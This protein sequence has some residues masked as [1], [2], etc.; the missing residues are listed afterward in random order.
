MKRS[1]QDKLIVEI[2][3]VT[4][5]LRGRTA[6]LITDVTQVIGSKWLVSDFDGAPPRFMTLE[7]PVRYAEMLLARRLQEMG[8]AEQG[9]RTLTHWKQRRGETGSELFFTTV[10]GRA[11]RV[12]E[13]RSF[14][15]DHPHLLFSSN[16]L[17][18]AVAADHWADHTV[19]VMFEHD[20]HLDYVVG[21]AGK[22]LTAGRLSTYAV[23]ARE[24]LVESI[25]LELR[26]LRNN[27]QVAVDKIVYFNWMVFQEE[28][29]FGATPSLGSFGK[30][31]TTGT[32]WGHNTATDS[33]SSWLTAGEKSNPG[34]QKVY[35]A[36]EW[37]RNLAG[38]MEIECVVSRPTRF[39]MEG[40]SFL[41]TALPGLV[42]RH[43][44]VAHTSS[45]TQTRLQYQTMRLAPLAAVAAWLL[46]AGVFW[47]AIALD[48]RAALLEQ[49]TLASG[50]ATTQQGDIKPLP[51]GLKEVLDYAGLLHDVREAPELRQIL[52]DL[53]VSGQGHIRL[54]KVNMQYDDRIRPSITITGLIQSGFEQAQ[55][56]HKDFLEKLQSLG[57]VIQESHFGTDVRELTFT[58]TLTRNPT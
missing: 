42:T 51:G 22:I 20:R 19:T 57:Y 28:E 15:D 29:Q 31:D 23:E 35:L 43:L 7:A 21:R 6:Q 32:G 9:S 39:E 10:N 12:Y 27:Q 52:S 40:S 38:E 36:S 14:E 3:G 46:L 2:D 16:A 24:S 4:V 8:E 37:V 18:A 45:P 50:T 5:H 33:T 1:R 25:R 53:S 30:G 41:S 44:T 49:E 56:V 26:N 55:M 11:F 34:D 58:I 54:D 13:D 48:S 17:L 47:S